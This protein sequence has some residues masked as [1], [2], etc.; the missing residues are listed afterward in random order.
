MIGDLAMRSLFSLFLI[1]AALAAPAL[2]TEVVSVPSFRSVQLRGGGV[3][4][5]APGENQRVTIVDGSS[6][7]THVW[8]E[9]NG[10]LKI[11]TC[12]N[13]CPQHYRMRILI[14]S[15]RVPDLGV[16]GGGL[17]T[18]QNG[19]KPQS[20]IS[21]AVNGGG[22]IDSRSVNIAS[23]SAAVNGGGEALVRAN[24]NLSAAV[25]GGGL[26]RYTG[27]PRVSSAIHGGGV[28]TPGN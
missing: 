20:Q 12:N 3:V 16:N 22:K 18:V 4:S 8:V 19:F 21:L 14:E 23:V 9:R 1:A 26:V 27:N 11:D 13:R 24:S 7:F 25:N 2:A 17:I 10:Q 15:P 6:Q 28:V 5:L